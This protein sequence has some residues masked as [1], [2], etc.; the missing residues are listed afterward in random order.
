M[1][2]ND[3]EIFLEF[4]IA[5]GFKRED[6]N[7]I[8]ELIRSASDSLSRNLRQ[9]K[10]FLLSRKV[11]YNELKEHCINGACGYLSNN[12]IIVPKTIAADTYF[13]EKK[14]N[15]TIYKSPKFLYTYP[16][17]DSY[18]ASIAYH[19][20]THEDLNQVIELIK[21]NQ[22]ISKYIGFIANKN[23]ELLEKKLDIY[24]RLLL[25]L[26]SISYD[27]YEIVHDSISKENKELYLIKRKY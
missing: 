19:D 4:L 18:D 15:K 6:Y 25:T 3:V 2:K 24:S 22:K 7:N 17:I 21:L 16:K 11:N 23:D 12:E 9:Y 27:K 5:N 13:E 14:N 8:L 20:F 26:N 10:Q 1:E